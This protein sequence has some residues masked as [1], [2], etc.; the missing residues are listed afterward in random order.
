MSASSSSPRRRT[1]KSLAL[2]RDRLGHWNPQLWRELQGRLN[3]KTLA[4]A[5]VCSLIVQ[6][7]FVFLCFAPVND[8]VRSNPLDLR[9]DFPHGAA[10]AIHT[11]INNEYDRSDG[12]PDMKAL[13][14]TCRDDRHPAIKAWTEQALA[15]G[16]GFGLHTSPY[17]TG[18]MVPENSDPLCLG[19]GRGGYGVSWSPVAR[20]ML[21]WWRWFTMALTAIGGAYCI[22]QSWANETKLGT[23]AFIRLSPE[24][25]SRLL[26]GKVLGT[27]ALVYLFALTLLPLHLGLS[28]LASLPWSFKVASD[29]FAIALAGT[30]L[31]AS[32]TA[33]IWT[34]TPSLALLAL[35]IPLLGLGSTLMGASDVAAY[36]DPNTGPEAHWYGL[37]LFEEPTLALVLG[38]VVLLALAQMLWRSAIRRFDDPQSTPLTRWQTYGLAIAL[39]GLALGFFVPIGPPTSSFSG[40]TTF[41]N[42]GAV[43]AGWLLYQMFAIWALFPDRQRLLDWCRY[44]HLDRTAAKV[45]GRPMTPHRRAINLG[46]WIWHEDSPPLAV[47]AILTGLTIILWSPWAIALTW[48]IA[49]ALRPKDYS[50]Q[51]SVQDPWLCLGGL[52]IP[53]ALLTALLALCTWQFLMFH[54]KSRPW[55]LGTVFGVALLPLGVLL[56]VLALFNGPTYMPIWPWLLTFVG[57][58][59]LPQAALDLHSLLGLAYAAAIAIVPLALCLRVTTRTLRHL[60]RSESQAL[61]SETKA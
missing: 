5:L 60:G 34:G 22:A 33:S 57:P 44:R 20:E 9:R 23:L 54:P 38:T 56:A 61:F 50:P 17:C 27:P 1:P 40:L 29:G 36:G 26:L 11:C 10:I 52:L 7:A 53:T 47:P 24:P 3:G 35:V 15:D 12:Y 19:D 45:Q 48:E 28:S 6:I 14:Q 37:S 58:V 55:M 13:V 42:W 18:P 51:L 59:L 30:I 2:W 32:L 21:P 16:Y 43:A 49:T 31:V 8:L 4:L 46:Q 41:Q 25:R 39:N